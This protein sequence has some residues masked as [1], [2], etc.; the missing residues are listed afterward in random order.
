MSVNV[1]EYEQPALAARWWQLALAMIAMMAASSPQYVWALF[2]PPLQAKLGVTLSALQVT[3]A[4]FSICQCGLGPMHGYLAEKFTPRQFAAMGGALVGASW[5]LSSYVLDLQLLYVTYGVLSGIGT[6]MIYVAAVELMTRWF[7]ERRGFAIG[8]VAGSYGFGAVITTF[9]IDASIR[10]SGY[11]HT[12]LIYGL[13]L[14]I[15]SILVA[16]GM[17][18][19]PID[20]ARQHRESLA[21]ASLGRR[22]YTSAEM[23][24]TPIFWLM[25]VMM[26]MMA[27]GGLMVI[28]QIGAFARDFGIGKDTLVLGMAALPLALTIDRIANGITRPFFGWV[29]DRIGRENTMTVAFLL[30][31]VSILLMQIFGS[32]PVW[33]VLLSGVIFFGWGEIYSLFPAIQGDL[34]G[35]KHA[36]NNFG[37]LLVATAVGSILGGPLAALL[38]EQSHSWTL[39][40]SIVSGLDVLTALL[41]LVVLKPMRQRFLEGDAVGREPAAS[42]L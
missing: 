15:V 14:G 42:L 30:E 25:F 41:A 11:Q 18:H 39:V 6:G 33:F 21:L 13:V 20:L 17:R 7:P 40:F 3:F 37:I 9:P 5:V 29:S 10:A 38:F 32:N 2:V 31:G 36:A 8:M 24:R 19:P 4:L 12:L 26:S 34:F 22:N 35:Q 27:T 1:L 28:S 16:L 23:L